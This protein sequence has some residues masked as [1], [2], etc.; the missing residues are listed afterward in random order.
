M[1]LLPERARFSIEFTESCQSKLDEI[2]RNYAIDAGLE[3]LL[4]ALAIDPH[5][6]PFVPPLVIWRAAKTQPYIHKGYLVPGL[7]F[8]FKIIED[9]LIV[10]MVD[11][12]V[13]SLPD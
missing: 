5:V 9:D 12:L 8:F 11:V 6:F 2:R 10:K 7:T 13:Q 4:E 3:V 1:S